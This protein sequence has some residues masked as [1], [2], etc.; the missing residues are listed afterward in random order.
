MET[1]ISNPAIASAFDVIILDTTCEG[2]TQ[3]EAETI[4]ETGKPILAVGKG[5]YE[6]L[7]YLGAQITPLE[8]IQ[9]TGIHVLS[10]S[11]SYNDWDIHYHIVYQ[12]PNHVNYET[13]ML[14]GEIT[15]RYLL[16]PL[17]NDNLTLTNSPNLIPLAK[18]TTKAD[19]YFL[20]IYNKY[21]SNPYLVHW[22]L[23]NITTISQ[24]PYGESCLQTL[25][26]TLHWLNDKT[27]YSVHIT[28]DYYEYGSLEAVNISIAAIDNLYQTLQGGITLDLTV[29]DDNQNTVHTDQ[30]VTSDIGPVY[31][32]FQLPTV[33]SPSYT[34]NVT[35]GSLF[36]LESFT[37]QPTDYQITEINATPS[38]FYLNEGEVLLNA[39]VTVEGNPAPNVIVYWSFINRITDPDVAFEDDPYSFTLLG[40]GV[41]NSSGYVTYHWVPEEFGIFEL[42]AWIRNYDGNPKNWTSTTVHVRGEPEMS[43]N[44]VSINP[45]I[46]VGDTVRI[47]G[48]LTLNSQ[49]LG[50]GMGINVS[51][52]EPDGRVIN[53]TVYTSSTGRFSL[54]WTPS[55]KGIHTIFC[56][57]AGNSTIDPVTKGLEFSA[58]QLIAALETNARDGQL[59]LGE[60]LQITATFAFI[61]IT[62]NLNDPVT[63]IVMNLDDNIVFSGEYTIDNLEYFQVQWTPQNTGYYKIMLCFNQ[64]YTIATTTNPIQVTSSGGNSDSS[65][66]AYLGL[67][68]S[69]LNSSDFSIPVPALLAVAGFGL[70][71]GV[72]LFTRLKKNRNEFLEDWHLSESNT[73]P[74]EEDGLEDEED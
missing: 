1:I 25:I 18:D 33:P 23:H 49:P 7:D 47:E 74:T 53:Y 71:G 58:Y 16:L 52:Y 44:L 27:P 69:N 51:I 24:D 14:Y 17:N 36:F 35:D 54:E 26:N 46:I 32:S 68:I 5:G 61:G 11:T 72:I 65:P 2:L 8:L 55:T 70:L 62:P 39:R 57:F 41:T 13:S 28:P 21:S 12:H 29:T 60:T 20:S 30:I 15:Q 9:D 37:V 6:F 4:A 31:T 63:L 73:E 22:A 56:T 10:I 45:P 34:I 3:S 19:N 64:S 43:I 59:P 48:N 40:Y 50:D 66:Q 67:S 42:V 38:T